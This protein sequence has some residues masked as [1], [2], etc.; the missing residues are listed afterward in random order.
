MKRRHFL[1]LLGAAGVT[2]GSGATAKAASLGDVKGLPNAGGVLFDASRC[3]G[4]RKCEAACNQVNDLPKP[5]KAFDDL[6]VLDVKRRTDAKSYTIVN[7][8]VPDAGKPPVFRK[9]Q[10][11]HCMEPACAS[12]CFVAAFKKSET[13]AVVYDP[14]VCVGCRYCMVACPFNIPAYEYDKA[15]TPRVMKCTMCQPRLLEGKLP[16]CVEACPKEALIFGKRRELLNIA[17]DRIGGN[18][19]RYVEHVYGE[20]E[21][22]GTSWLT[23]APKPSFA[24]IGMDETLGTTSA[25]E[26]TSGALAAVPAV[27]GIW[28]VLLTGLY[29]ISKRKEK[30][31]ESE[32]QA[33]VAAAIAKASADAEA[34]LSEELGKAEVANKRRIEVEVKKAL[35]AAAKAGEEGEDA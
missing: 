21:M 31:A 29:A 35:E 19:G 32:K 15:F 33:A 2:L 3:I 8:Y 23:I 9:I 11:N 7:K 10:C 26:L 14:D 22:G 28:P 18:P 1:G 24:A 13:G 34:K 4:C 6:T 25:P 27:A 30:I 17:W 20:R 12:A 5:A 16:G